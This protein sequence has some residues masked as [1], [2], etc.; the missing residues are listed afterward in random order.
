VQCRK[1]AKTVDKFAG[2]LENLQ[3]L[4]GPKGAISK[5]DQEAHKLELS[6]SLKK[7]G[8]LKTRLLPRCTSF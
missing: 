5:E 7:P 8:R 1:P 2:T 3:K 6:Q 4:N